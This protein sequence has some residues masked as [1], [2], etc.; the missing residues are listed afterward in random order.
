ML[1]ICII[2]YLNEYIVKLSALLEV[3]LDYSLI[4]I[5]NIVLNNTVDYLVLF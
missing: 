2:K 1:I 4:L 5:I 3:I